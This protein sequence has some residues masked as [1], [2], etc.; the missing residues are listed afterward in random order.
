MTRKCDIVR[1][2]MYGVMK[3]DTAG[4]VSITTV[5]SVLGASSLLDPGPKFQHPRAESCDRDAKTATPA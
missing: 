3:I 1:I 2:M 4:V 5:Q